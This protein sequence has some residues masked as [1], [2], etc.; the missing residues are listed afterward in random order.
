M[1]SQPNQ[2]NLLDPKTPVQ[3]PEPPSPESFEYETRGGSY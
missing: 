3:L 1:N 2:N